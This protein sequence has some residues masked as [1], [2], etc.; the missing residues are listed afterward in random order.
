M[1]QPCVHISYQRLIKKQI[2]DIVAHSLNPEDSKCVDHQWETLH[3]ECN[4]GV[5]FDLGQGQGQVEHCQP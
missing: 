1:I 2:H 5:K 4:F 3:K